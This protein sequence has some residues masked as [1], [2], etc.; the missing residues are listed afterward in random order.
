VS[1]SPKGPGTRDWVREPPATMR[2]WVTYLL[3]GRDTRDVINA[4]EANPATRGR[5]SSTSIIVACSR[6]RTHGGFSQTILPGGPPAPLYTP[7]TTEVRKVLDLKGDEIG[8]RAHDVVARITEWV[9]NED[10]L[11]IVPTLQGML[12]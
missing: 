9:V 6:L 1:Y 11:D 8:I 2:D 10:L 12:T 5:W 3:P 4:I 7:L